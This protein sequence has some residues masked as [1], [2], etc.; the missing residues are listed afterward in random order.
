MG[1][2]FYKKSALNPSGPGDLLWGKSATTSS[3]SFGVKGF[4][5]K[6]NCG[7]LVSKADM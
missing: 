6:A 4:S 7:W 5:R 2:H 3:I 1:Q